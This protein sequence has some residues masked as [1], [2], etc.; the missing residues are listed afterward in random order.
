[1]QPRPGMLFWTFLAALALAGVG[2]LPHALRSLPRL[3]RARFLSFASGVSLS[4]VVL[5]LLPALGAEEAL[6]RAQGAPALPLPAGEEVYGVVLLSMLLFYAAEV[7]SRRT[8]PGE[9]LR[10][11][12]ARGLAVAVE[13]GSFG[14]LSFLVGFTLLHRAG[15]GWRELLM[16]SIAMFLK[17]IVSDHALHAEHGRAY[18]RV[19]RWVLAGSVLAG[20]G[21]GGVVALP[22]LGPVLLEAFIAG[23]VIFNVL[24]WEVPR[25]RAGRYGW[26]LLGTLAY[27]GLLLAIY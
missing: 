27:A 12:P 1:M 26:F 20:W 17:F 16:F 15:A 10:A 18:D 22:A 2:A 14:A 21:L 5:R 8:A 11:P 3:P 9:P 24:R 7:L 23:G 13:I 4:F 19:G 6:V 25:S